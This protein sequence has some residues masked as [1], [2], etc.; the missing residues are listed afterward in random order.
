MNIIVHI[1]YPKF[2]WEILESNTRHD[3]NLKLYVLE[4]EQIK[5]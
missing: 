2:P 1:H 5:K 3:R 4:R